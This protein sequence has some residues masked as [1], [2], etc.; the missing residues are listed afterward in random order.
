MCLSSSLGTERAQIGPGSSKTL[1]LVVVSYCQYYPLSI[2]G[3]RPP[4]LVQKIREKNVGFF[5]KYIY[6]KAYTQQK[7]NSL[8][9]SF[10]SLK[11]KVLLKPSAPF[12]ACLPHVR[13]RRRARG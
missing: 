8:G 6:I 3:W 10:V 4:Y 2:Q 13:W 9:F 12:T 5:H 7:P 1:V 11:P